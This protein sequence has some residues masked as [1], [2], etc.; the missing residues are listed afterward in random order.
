M[1][2]FLDIYIKDLP[3]AIT[4]KSE[5]KKLMSYSYFRIGD[6]VLCDLKRANFIKKLIGAKGVENLNN[7]LKTI[8]SRLH[9]GMSAK[10]YKDLLS[11]KLDDNKKT[12][13]F[14]EPLF[15]LG[16][17]TRINSFLGAADIE[18]VGDLLHFCAMNPNKLYELDNIGESSIIK[19]G[20]MINELDSRLYLGMS[21]VEIDNYMKATLCVEDYLEEKQAEE[22]LAQR[23]LINRITLT[24]PEDYYNNCFQWHPKNYVIRNLYSLILAIYENKT[25]GLNIKNE[26]LLKDEFN[27]LN[28]A[29]IYYGMKPYELT[30][31]NINTISE[32]MDTNLYDAEETKKDLED[33]LNALY[34]QKRNLSDKLCEID[35]RIN[36][37]QECIL[38]RNNYQKRY[39]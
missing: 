30:I 16:L 1:D 17:T 39:K 4:L 31:L 34:I 2:N 36:Y 27:K 32:K 37:L 7:L 5:I 3:N 19:L 9:I 26:K 33:E 15:N 21:E 22:Q 11:G 8:D 14:N 24:N 29:G 35:V 20:K 10:E 25:R 38:N 6:L 13:I 12:F 23:R 28:I 18:T